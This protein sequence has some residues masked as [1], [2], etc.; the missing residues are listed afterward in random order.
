MQ[1]HVSVCGVFI[2]VFIS[3]TCGGLAVNV[4]SVPNQHGTYI[5]QYIYIPFTR[6]YNDDLSFKLVNL[7]TARVR[8]MILLCLSFATHILAL[9]CAWSSPIIKKIIVLVN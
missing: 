5:H 4:L 2:A 3:L 9:T 1:S 6:E 7:Y 8:A